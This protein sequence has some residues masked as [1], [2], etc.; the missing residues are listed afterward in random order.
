MSDVG[1]VAV[2][3]PNDFSEATTEKERENFVSRER[4]RDF[5]ARRSRE[6]F[7]RALAFPKFPSLRSRAAAPRETAAHK[8][9]MRVSLADLRLQAD[10]IL[11]RI[12]PIPDRSRHL[13]AIVIT[14]HINIR[15]RKRNQLKITQH[16]GKRQYTED[17]ATYNF[18][19]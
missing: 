5:Q 18:C 16:T 11:L 3:R 15:R 7:L 2:R 19:S 13:P 1:H 12:F 8:C 9:P 10:V 14:I 6:F 4:R 17:E